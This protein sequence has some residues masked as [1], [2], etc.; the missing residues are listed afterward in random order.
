M[1]STKSFKAA[2]F[3]V[4]TFAL[5]FTQ[6]AYAQNIFPS[7]SV[8]TVYYYPN[9]YSYKTVE[10]TYY[11]SGS[12]YNNYQGTSYRNTLL[13]NNH[14]ENSRFNHHYRH[15]CYRHNHH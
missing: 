7:A 6:N 5:V 8:R 11:S 12:R 13:I 9:N 14:R 4:F 2:A 15:S 3:L 1:R 10:T